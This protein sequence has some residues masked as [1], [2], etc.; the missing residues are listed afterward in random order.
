MRFLSC[1]EKMCRMCTVL[2]VV[3]LLS[4]RPASASIDVSVGRLWLKVTSDNG[5]PKYQFGVYAAP[6]AAPTSAPTATPTQSP[7]TLAPTTSAPTSPTAAPTVSPTTT[8]PT[9]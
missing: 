7:T 2:A 1:Y 9:T 3:L 8:S 4:A 6:T 5:P